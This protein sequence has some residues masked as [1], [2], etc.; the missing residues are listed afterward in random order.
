MSIS[1]MGIMRSETHVYSRD[2][3][4]ASVVGIWGESMI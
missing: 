2:D 1:A 4:I 3:V